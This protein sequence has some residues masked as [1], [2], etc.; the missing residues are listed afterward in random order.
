ME[1]EPCCSER[2]GFSRASTLAVKGS[3]SKRHHAADEQSRRPRLHFF[4]GSA[5][6]PSVSIG[7][8]DPSDGAISPVFT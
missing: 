2:E 6:S 5:G 3:R 8:D 1:G 7:I 4:F